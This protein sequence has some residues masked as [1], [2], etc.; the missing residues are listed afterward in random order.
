VFFLPRSEVKRFRM[1]IGHHN[2]GKLEHYRCESMEEL[3]E[4]AISAAAFK[5]SSEALARPNARRAAGTSRDAIRRPVQHK[6][7][8]ARAENI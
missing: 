4:R 8:I 1:C 2:V 6:F 7:A 5:E 3:T